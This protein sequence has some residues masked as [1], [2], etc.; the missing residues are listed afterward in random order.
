MTNLYS[1]NGEEP[2]ELPQRIRLSD[3]STKTDSS[4]FTDDE[5]KD[6]GFVGPYSTPDIDEETQ[7]YVWNIETLSYEVV[8]LPP[9]PPE[10]TDEDLWFQLRSA[11]NGELSTTDWIIM[12][13]S[14]LSEEKKQEWITYRQA[15]RDLPQTTT[16]P[17]NFVWPISP[18]E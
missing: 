7:Y 10:P 4:T 2:R 18:G 15:L 12:P 13:D 1:I 11:R 5:I 14:P 3:G 8:D 16:D 6:A 9:P 17:R